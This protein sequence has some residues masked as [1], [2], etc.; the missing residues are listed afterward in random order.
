MIENNFA[1]SSPGSMSFGQKTFDR[2]II[3][4]W[5]T[6]HMADTH[7]AEIYSATRHFLTDI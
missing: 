6:G 7:L 4:W 2:L 1:R 5:T 3:G